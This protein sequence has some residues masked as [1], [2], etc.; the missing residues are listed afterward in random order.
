MKKVKDLKFSLKRQLIT[1]KAD[2][3]LVVVDIKEKMMDDVLDVEAINILID[4][5]YELKKAK[6]KAYE[7]IIEYTDR[8]KACNSSV[9]CR[10]LLGCDI[11]TPDGMKKANEEG[12][13]D[14]ICT[15]MVREASEILEE[16]LDS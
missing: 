6:A 2:I 12:L 5:K 16:M 7:K 1:S 15:K 4:K 11:S 10:E 14:S 3:D 8:F 13:F 9:V